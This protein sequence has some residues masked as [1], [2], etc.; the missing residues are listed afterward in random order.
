VLDGDISPE[1]IR[2]YLIGSKEYAESLSSGTT[3]RELSGARMAELAVPIAP[4]LEQRRVVAKLDQLF[5][6][7]ARARADLD[8]IRI[9]I[10]KYKEAL[11]GAA[12]S[13]ELTHEWREA[14]DLEAPTEVALGEIAV[15]FTTVRQQSHDHPARCRCF[16]WVTS[17]VASS[18]GR[19]SC[20]RQ[21]R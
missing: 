9:L 3:F 1:F 8:R 7:T 6:R 11:L 19:I 14:E 2:Y 4:L 12:F 13:G 16:A 20:I 21:I 15:D 17:K 10:G 18:T 5:E